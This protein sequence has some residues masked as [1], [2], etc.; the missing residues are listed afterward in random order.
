MT[1]LTYT[2]KFLL[3]FAL[4]ISSVTVVF[5][6]A[7]LANSGDTPANT[8]HVSGNTKFELRH[9]VTSL[10]GPS[11]PYWV[12]T[13]ESGKTI[14]EI[15]QAY[16][17]SSERSPEELSLDGVSIHS[18]EHVS[19]V[20]T[21]DTLDENYGILSHVTEVTVGSPQEEA[22]FSQPTLSWHCHGNVSP[23]QEVF[24]EAWYA[25]TD[26]NNHL[27]HMKAFSTSGEGDRIET[28][29]MTTDHAVEMRSGGQ[30]SYRAIEN[31]T[32]ARL[33]VKSPMGKGVF[34][35]HQF[36]SDLSVPLTSK[37]DLTCIADDP[38]AD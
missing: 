7:S 5:P 21:L 19:V 2:R 29:L 6:S 11:Q 25:T 36:V 34:E 15:D 1:N 24:V 32:D 37:V 13:L 18:G 4:G 20:A 26:G 10:V 12:V 16:S 14:F 23:N 38:L 31:S 8:V 22:V 30:Y 27:Y 35:L 17:I 33:T 9:T 3:S 28:N